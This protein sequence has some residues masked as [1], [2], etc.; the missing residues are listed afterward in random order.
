[1]NFYSSVINFEKII[2]DTEDPIIIIEYNIACIILTYSYIESSLNEIINLAKDSKTKNLD[3]SYI[4][5]LIKFERSTTIEN[6][7]KALAGPLK[8]TQWDYSCE[9]FQSFKILN[10][11]RNELIHFKGGWQNLNTS[12]SKRIDDLIIKL[13]IN[14]EHIA[15][16]VNILF[17]SKELCSWTLSLLKKFQFLFE[18]ILKT[19]N[20]SVKMK[21]IEIIEKLKVNKQ[22]LD[23][24][25][26]SNPFN[27][28][29]S[30][31]DSNKN[32]L[33]IQCP[34]KAC[35]LFKMLNYVKNEK[36]FPESELTFD[37]L[38]EILNTDHLLID[39]L[40]LKSKSI[41]D[42]IKFFP[43]HGLKFHE[44]ILLLIQHMLDSAGNSTFDIKLD[45]VTNN[46][47]KID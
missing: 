6:K 45:E 36:Y 40:I 13:K 8:T 14:A 3:D 33:E 41:K 9:P 19:L 30:I 17:S 15:G 28:P 38:L 12:P 32:L 34:H 5:L 37:K 47:F 16:W 18:E 29:K 39:D 23:F 20:K 22:D 44:I 43:D 11:I 46:L 26:K 42:E 2:Q 25:I 24:L 31:L 10:S 27:F 35:Q 4:D 21:T 1:M 7:F